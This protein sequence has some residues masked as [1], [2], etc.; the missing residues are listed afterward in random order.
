MHSES[1]GARATDGKSPYM[2]KGELS[3]HCL[4]GVGPG[5]SFEG[6]AQVAA[7]I[8]TKHQEDRSLCSGLELYMLERACASPRGA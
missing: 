6:T 8:T 7:H 2:G 4:Q 3:D 5:T 1:S